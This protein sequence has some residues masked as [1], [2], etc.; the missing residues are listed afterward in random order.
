MKDGIQQNI[1][2][3][4][5]LGKVLLKLMQDLAHRLQGSRSKFR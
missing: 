3:R 5:F 2:L 4:Y 1:F